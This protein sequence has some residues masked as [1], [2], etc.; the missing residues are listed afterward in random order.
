MEGPVFTPVGEAQAKDKHHQVADGNDRVDARLVG[1]F[2]F[3]QGGK[4]VRL[5]RNNA[6]GERVVQEDNAGFPMTGF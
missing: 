6:D 2:H 5:Q 3:N 1:L 4:H